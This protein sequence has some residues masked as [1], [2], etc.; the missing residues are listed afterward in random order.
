MLEGLQCIGGFRAKDN[1][2]IGPELSGSGCVIRSNISHATVL[3]DP[4]MEQALRRHLVG[5]DEG[6]RSL[7][8]KMRRI[9]LG[10]I[11]DKFLG[12]RLDSTL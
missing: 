8:H 3:V 7:L 11:E 10:Q 1:L 6:S 9:Y 4:L 2:S 12:M 5:D